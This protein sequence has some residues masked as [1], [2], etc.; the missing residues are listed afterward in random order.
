MNW[1][2]GL[3]R[4][5]LVLSVAWIGLYVLACD[6]PWIEVFS[7]VPDLKAMFIPP[8]ILFFLGAGVLW[9]IGGFAVR[10]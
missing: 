6:I 10:K 3:F 8:A 7:R 9:A 2:R 4:A 1:W 5:W